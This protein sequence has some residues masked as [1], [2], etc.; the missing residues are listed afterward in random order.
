MTT[1]QQLAVQ[2]GART[3]AILA[4][5]DDTTPAGYALHTA[6]THLVEGADTITTLTAIVEDYDTA[7]QRD[8]EAQRTAAAEARR[9]ELVREVYPVPC[10][11]CPAEAG[12]PCV[13][14]NGRPKALD[15]P[16]A[17]RRTA[18]TEGKADR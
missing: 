2:L 16:H 7:A 13:S 8:L 5:L 4:E 6:L 15:T 12:Q 1:K 3:T 10:P 17:A 9:Q 11:V 18:A 14:A